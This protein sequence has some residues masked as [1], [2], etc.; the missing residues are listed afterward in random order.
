LD[1]ASGRSIADPALETLM[2]PFSDGQLSWPAGGRVM[3]LNGRAGSALPAHARHWVCQQDFRPDADRLRAAGMRVV[4]AVDA[5][6]HPMVLVLPPRQ[7]AQSR[8]LLARALELAGSDGVVLASAANDE[9]ARSAEADL[10]Q[11]A[12]PLCSMVKNHCRVFWSLP[13]QR[14]VDAILQQSWQDA[15]APR[16]IAG[17]RLL[18]RPGVFAWDRID[19]ASAMLADCLPAGLSGR[20]ADFGAGVGYLSRRLLEHCPGITSLD[21]FEADWRALALARENVVAPAARQHSLALGFHW[22]DVASG[23]PG[24]FDFVVS[25]PPFH[26]GKAGQPELGRA[27]IAAAAAALQPTGCLWLVAN[28]HLP[29]EAELARRFTRVRTVRDEHGFKVIEAGGARK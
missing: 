22:H 16:A 3:F 9:G 1:V 12:G 7:R 27:F 24:T 13:G 29:Y 25:N 2:L 14:Q 21:L 10:R 15:D 11:L 18:S 23:V 6:P 19:S 20:G 26:Q 5:A 8:A 17:G 4:Q 28:R